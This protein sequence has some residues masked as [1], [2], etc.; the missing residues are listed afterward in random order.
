MRTTNAM[1][2]SE[3]Q[4]FNDRVKERV[5]KFYFPG[6]LLC[7]N[8]VPVDNMTRSAF[9]KLAKILETEILMLI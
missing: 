7:E 9:M 3:I 6:I 4:T 5:S 1:L 8:W 2:G